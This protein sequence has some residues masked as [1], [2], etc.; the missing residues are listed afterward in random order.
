M[1]LGFKRLITILLWGFRKNLN[2]HF[3][4]FAV[5][6]C[7]DTI[8]NQQ[9]NII[10]CRR[11]LF[12]CDFFAVPIHIF[13]CTVRTLASDFMLV[14]RI[15]DWTIRFLQAVSI[16]LYEQHSLDFLDAFLKLRKATIIF[17]MSVRPSAGPKSAPT[18]RIFMKFDIWGFFEKL[19]RKFKFYY[20]RTRTKGTAHEHPVQYKNTNIHYLSYL[21]H[22]FLEWEMF[23]T[24]VRVVVKNKTHILCSSNFFFRKSCSLWDNVE[25]F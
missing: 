20:N 3:V 18:R 12:H 14:S 15:L 6:C 16:F 17:V 2:F 5:F 4:S 24:K 7:L 9:Q 1:S 10:K 25:K 8:C 19:T 22:F 21:A 23:Q 13:N 11:L